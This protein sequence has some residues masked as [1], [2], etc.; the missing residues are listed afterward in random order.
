MIAEIIS[1]YH[2]WDSASGVMLAP[3]PIATVPAMAPMQPAK[4]R[5]VPTVSIASLKIVDR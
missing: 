3:A 2:I 1:V 5:R 4:M